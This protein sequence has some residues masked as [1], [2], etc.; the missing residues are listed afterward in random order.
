MIWCLENRADADQ[1]DNLSERRALLER[2]LNAGMATEQVC[3]RLQV[4]AAQDED[5]N[6][7]SRIT[8]FGGDPALREEA[9]LLEKAGQLGR[10]QQKYTEVCARV[11]S[12]MPLINF[13]WRTGREDEAEAALRQHIL[14]GNRHSLLDLAKHLRQRGRSLEADRLRRSGLE[15][16][17]STST[18]TPPPV[19]R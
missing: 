11:G 9:A 15:P 16:D 1:P 6:E 2:A 7:L 18:W 14:A 4:I 5:W 10:A 17:G 3:Q 19:L 8:G 12:R 13:W